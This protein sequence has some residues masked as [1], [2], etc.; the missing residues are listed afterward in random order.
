[1]LLQSLT[2]IMGFS[3]RQLSIVAYLNFFFRNVFDYHLFF[4]IYF[5]RYYMFISVLLLPC[6]RKIRFRNKPSVF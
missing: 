1:M 6:F 3:D 5:L 2:K 4:G